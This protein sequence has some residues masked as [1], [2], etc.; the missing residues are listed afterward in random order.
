MEQSAVA[1]ELQEL[2]IR[3]LN[4]KVTV[5]S[6]EKSDDM[7]VIVGNAEPLNRID[8]AIIREAALQKGY[9]IEEDLDY[10]TAQDDPEVPVSMYFY[11][12]KPFKQP[13]GIF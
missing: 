13:E 4:K 5:Q 3:R 2:Y 1:K 8:F 10:K 11:P 6:I 12:L 7:C 9:E